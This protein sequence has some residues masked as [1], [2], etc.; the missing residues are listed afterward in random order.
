[1]GTPNDIFK[2]KTALQLEEIE[3][4]NTGDL[5]ERQKRE[6]EEKIA[7]DRFNA[8]AIE[9]FEEHPEALLTYNTIKAEVASSIV[10]KNKG[11]K[12]QYTIA[13]VAVIAIFTTLTVPFLFEKEDLFE[14]KPMG[15]NDDQEE[16]I[17]K[18]VISPLM[19]ELSDEAIENST[20]LEAPEI[21]QPEDI[22][23]TSPVVVDQQYAI[24][25]TVINNE[26]KKAMEIK[27]IESTKPSLI[28]IT[29]PDDI[30]YSNVKTFYMR[31]FLLV[32][33]SDI[34]TGAIKVTSFVL[35]GTSAMLENK[36]DQLNEVHE[37]DIVTKLIPYKTYLAETQELFGE[38]NFKQSLKKYKVILAH[39]P[40]DL[41]AHFYSGLCYYNLGKP[42]KALEHFDIAIQHQYNTFKIDAEWYKA[43]TYYSIGNIETCR[44]LLEK[45]ID[46]NNYYQSQAAQLLL[47]L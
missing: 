19:E 38:S 12:F 27:R 4:Y 6:V 23:T 32:D 1:M 30:V 14:S 20:P 35:T 24:D 18:E 15:Q 3:R 21:V 40:Y 16:I 2:N 7:Q 44:E 10:S 47:Q 29:T 13:L 46:A 37:T 31:K 26:I 5:S 36:E 11:W 22:I 42:K 33:Y 8:D 25:E 34:Y 9:G 28:S 17:A 45:I 41:N 39:Y 43:K